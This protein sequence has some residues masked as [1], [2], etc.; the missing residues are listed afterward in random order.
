MNLS[1]LIPL[2]LPL[3]VAGACAGLLAG[4]LGVG[5]GIVIVPA[6]FF[7]FSHMQVPHETAMSLATA[8]SLATIVPT[9]FSSWRAHGAK[10]N[11]DLAIA[12]SWAPFLILG[13]LL[14]SSLVARLRSE[15]FTLVFVAVAVY[16]ASRM[17]LNPSRSV[18]KSLPGLAI[19]RM[20]ACCVGGISAIA[21]VGG[22]ALI[23][24]FLTA[25]GVEP[26]RA[27]GTSALFG[28]LVALPATLNL[29][30]FASTPVD[31]PQ[32]CIGMV[33]W[34][35]VLLIVPLTVSIAPLGVRLGQQLSPIILKRVFGCCLLVMSGR[36]LYQVL[37]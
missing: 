37:C 10:G 1:E 31:A 26:R 30:L 27:I 36:M 25:F 23:V 33:N 35:A 14:G 12:K 13:V 24:P 34:I 15:L 7:V 21:G 28:L 32:G 18:A 3:L 11:V 29:L 4:L 8:T 22:G 19:Q 5:G 6:L 16:A 9:A 20:F 17:L 2:I